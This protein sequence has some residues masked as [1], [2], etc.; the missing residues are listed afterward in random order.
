MKRAFSLFLV[1]ALCLALCAC[2]VGNNTTSTTETNPMEATN[3]STFTDAT[4]EPT[5]GSATEPTTA[6]TTTTE[7]TTAPTSEP[8][9]KPTTTPT[10]ESTTAPTT[11]ST[12]A[13][14]T[15]ST[16]APTT[17][18]TTAPTTEP[19]HIHSF[20]A[21]TCTTPRICSCGA[22]EGSANGH[23]WKKATC[24]TPKTCSVCGITEGGA[25]DHMWTD[26]TCTAPKTCSKCGATNGSALGHSYAE[27][28]CS[29]CSQLQ[30]NYHPL[31][32]GAWSTLIGNS[33]SI[34][35]SLERHHLELWYGANIDQFESDFR[36]VLISDYQNGYK[37][38]K[39]I[40]GKYYYFGAGDGGKIT[41]T[42]NGNII[43]VNC[44]DYIWLTLER[45]A[46]DQLKIVA[47]EG[48]S[49]R[50][51]GA[52][53]SWNKCIANEYSTTNHPYKDGICA[54]GARQLGIGK[55]HNYRLSGSTL[56]VKELDED[57]IML[58]QYLDIE[59]GDPEK[60]QQCLPGKTLTY[61]NR[62][63]VKWT[64]GGD[65]LDY[66]HI[67]D[68]SITA[69]LSLGPDTELQTCIWK[70]ISDDQIVVAEVTDQFWGLNVGDIF[71]YVE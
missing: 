40:D 54:C 19:L 5:N 36:D 64:G 22:T 55:W 14:T 48:V 13:P 16:A 61:Q 25:L 15:E 59:T 31:G 6:T 24:T 41:Y 44:E 3:A 29:R 34:T 37:H 60:V 26:A 52:V 63:Y 69:T 21:A 42:V 2:T 50:I 7:P 8:T 32:T 35:L 38:V 28:V 39:L 53:L 4:T 20:S 51:V 33:Y 17:E 45:I 49:S 30:E 46:G 18:S 47:Q 65:S 43:S 27:G 12:T 10:T 57:G 66:E 67:S 1:L 11:E 56:T 9:T 70:R 68:N 62:T 71:I 23:S 58:Y